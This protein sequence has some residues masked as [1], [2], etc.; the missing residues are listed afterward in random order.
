[1]ERNG[2]VSRPTSYP[3]DG[4]RETQTSVTLWLRTSRRQALKLTFAVGSQASMQL[5]SATLGAHCLLRLPQQR[6]RALMGKCIT[7]GLC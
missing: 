5:R 3:R 7:L 4:R 1:M 6:E 2:R